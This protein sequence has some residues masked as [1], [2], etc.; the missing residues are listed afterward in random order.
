MSSSLD[1][2]RLL[3]WIGSDEAKRQA[4]GGAAARERFFENI[5]SEHFSKRGVYSDRDMLCAAAVKAGCDEGR[6][7]QFLESGRDEDKIRQ[8]FLR[9]YYGWGDGFSS[10]PITLF[11]CEGQEYAI[12]GSSHLRDYVDV[13]DLCAR[14]EQRT[15]PNARA[16]WEV[17]DAEASLRTNW[18][19]LEQ[20]VFGTENCGGLLK[21]AS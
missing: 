2:S 18:R 19:E 16:G 12:R 11:S 7:R 20:R 10:I 15:Y 17:L 3:L 4:R 9:V 6:V 14:Q 1:A 13:L 5:V 21:T 8:Q